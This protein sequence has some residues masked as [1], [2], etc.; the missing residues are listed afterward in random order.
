MATPQHLVLEVCSM[1][2]TRDGLENPIRRRAKQLYETS[3]DLTRRRPADMRISMKVSPCDQDIDLSW[4][5]MTP[6]LL[7][8]MQH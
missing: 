6:K 4:Q 2:M 8:G 1:T 5:M 3:F 7:L